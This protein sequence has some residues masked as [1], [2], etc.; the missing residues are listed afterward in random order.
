MSIQTAIVT[1]AHAGA[2]SAHARPDTLGSRVRGNDEGRAPAILFSRDKQVRFLEAL[3]L[4]G[5]ARAACRNACVSHQTVYRHRRAS[6]DFALAW[7]AAVLVARPQVEEVLADRA[8]NGIEEVVYYHGEEVARRRRYDSR[9][10]L[11]HLARLDRAEE[12]NDILDVAHDFDA[13]LE[14]LR[15][16]EPIDPHADDDDGDDARA[17]YGERWEDESLPFPERAELYQRW[18]EAQDADAEDDEDEDGD[19]DED[20]DEDEDDDALPD[21]LGPSYDDEDADEHETEEPVDASLYV[22]KDLSQDRVTPVTP[23]TL[24]QDDAE[25]PAALEPAA[26]AETCAP[27]PR[28]RAPAMP[29][30]DGRCAAYRNGAYRG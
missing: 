27:V 30:R 13:A 10:L 21:P 15:R 1:P 11:A 25:R 12:S 18:L 22:R 7:D 23:V 5:S 14:R 2:Q 28:F 4:W 17:I 26:A 24:Q 19:E 3:A 29:I 16:G 8:L 20:E 9:L 6:R